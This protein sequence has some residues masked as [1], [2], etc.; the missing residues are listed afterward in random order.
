M[1]GG[2]G[3]GGGTTSTPTGTVSGATAPTGGGEIGMGIQMGL[4]TEMMKA[5]KENIE[6]NTEKTKVD[7]AKTAGVDTDAV[8]T[9]IDAVKTS[10]EKM[11]AETDNTKLQG[12]IMQFEKDLAEV[13]SKV[14]KGSEEALIKQNNADEANM[15]LEDFAK[16]AEK[17]KIGIETIKME[18]FE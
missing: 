7:T 2:G 13:N 11:K 12:G 4:A 3:A 6:A 17:E 9:G 8:K 1:Y 18:D 14:A 16:L 5:Q 10:I 15:T